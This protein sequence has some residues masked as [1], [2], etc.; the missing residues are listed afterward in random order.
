[1]PC[2]LQP[3]IPETTDL[4]RTWMITKHQPSHLLALPKFVAQCIDFLTE[5]TNNRDIYVY[6]AALH[7]IFSNLIEWSNDQF[8]PHLRE[9]SDRIMARVVWSSRLFSPHISSHLRECGIQDDR[10]LW[11]RQ[12]ALAFDESVIKKTPKCVGIFSRV[13]YGADILLTSIVIR[14]VIKR[15]PD[16]DVVVLGDRCIAGLFE[17]VKTVDVED[18]KYPRRGLLVDRILSVLRIEQ[19]LKEYEMDLIINPDSRLDQLG[20]VPFRC[21]IPMLLWHPTCPLNQTSGSLA[22]SIDKW[23]SRRLGTIPSCRP[24]IFFSKI[25][26]QCASQWKNIFGP[27]TIA[28]KLHHGGKPSKGLPFEY[29]IKLLERLASCGWRILL[30]KGT[31]IREEMESND[32]VHKLGWEYWDVQE[33]DHGKSRLIRFGETNIDECKLVRF[34]GSLPG[35]AAAVNGC[36]MALNY[37]SVGQHIA[38]ALNVNSVVVFR[39]FPNERFIQAWTP[40]S[41]AVVKV[42]R[43]DGDLDLSYVDHILD[44]IGFP[45]EYIDI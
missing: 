43:L 41:K 12:Q 34:Y 22:V 45:K 27:N 38:A 4:L 29:E 13:T 9:N 15:W 5:N 28:V 35:W 26:Q 23:L 40:P 24:G 42:V 8:I 44:E 39:D 17:G 1:M 19:V 6:S 25:F 18:I 32:L 37:D 30:S 16:V 11:E 20:L 33:N 31:G 3:N 21:N 7:A 10:A 36:G 2:L 14:H